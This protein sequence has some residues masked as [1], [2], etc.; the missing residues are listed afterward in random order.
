MKP[1]EGQVITEEADDTKIM[2][3]SSDE[4]L[5]E[6]SYSQGGSMSPRK[7]ETK[8]AVPQTSRLQ[9]TPNNRGANHNKGG[10]SEKKQ[11]TGMFGGF[12]KLFGY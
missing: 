10:G 9:G 8:K 6:Q 11:P 3:Q 2:A 7:E 12:L 4:R 1:F 5:R